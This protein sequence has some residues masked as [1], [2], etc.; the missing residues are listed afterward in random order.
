MHIGIWWGNLKETD[1]VEDLG[2]DGD[3]IKM[4]VKGIG[5]DLW[6]VFFFVAEIGT[7]MSLL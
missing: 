7:S 6:T 4:T 1:H 5:W 2:V 3:N